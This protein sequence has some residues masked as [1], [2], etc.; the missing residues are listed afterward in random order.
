M[1]SVNKSYT[2]HDICKPYYSSHDISK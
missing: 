2:G 1:T